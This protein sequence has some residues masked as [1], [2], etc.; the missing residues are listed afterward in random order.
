MGVRDFTS[1]FFID[2]E[3][4]QVFVYGTRPYAF[5]GMAILKLNAL[6]K[7]NEYSKNWEALVT[8]YLTLTAK[9]ISELSGNPR[10]ESE[11]FLNEL[12]DKGMLDKSTT[13]NGAIWNTQKL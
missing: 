5:Y 4:N 1:L 2:S 9:E 11:I 6:I 8:K 7:K 13:W 3:A 12:I 10:R